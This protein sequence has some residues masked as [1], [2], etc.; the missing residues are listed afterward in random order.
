[1]VPLVEAAARAGITADAMR[2][3]CAR[4]RVP[5]AIKMDGLWYVP[6][7]SLPDDRTVT[8]GVTGVSGQPSRTD[9]DRSMTELVELVRAQGEQLDAMRAMLERL[10]AERA[11]VTAPDRT[12]R[13]WWRGAWEVLFP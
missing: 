10:T 7:S 8:N 4:S 11:N 6:V 2:K 5:G 3:K 9:V 12:D 13:P 1:M